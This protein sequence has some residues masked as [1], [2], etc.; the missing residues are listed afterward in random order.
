MENLKNIWE[1]VK[2]WI[3][4]FLDTIG[5]VPTAILKVVLIIVAAK[6]LIVI[7]AAIIKRTLYRKTQK[8]PG[9]LAAKKSETIATLITSASKYL[10]YFIGAI[11]ILDAIG[12]GATIGSVIATAGIGGIALSLGAQS[13][14]K[15]VVAGFF[16]LLEDEYAVGDLVEICGKQGTVESI[17]L[18]TTRLRLF[19][20]EILAI[21]NGMVDLVINYTRDSY[22]LPYTASI[23]YE[24]DEDRAAALLMEAASELAD[25]EESILE[26]P[27]YLGISRTGADGIDI[28][29]TLKVKPQDQWQ[30]ERDL[31]AAVIRA[32]KK[33]GIKLPLHT[34]VT[35]HNK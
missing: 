30:I 13:F 23:A 22:T 16:I 11:A 32:F 3:S 8:A 26:A 34:N 2:D 6:L 20:N 27:T 31:N 1:S 29:I 14:I 9:T 24:E 15:D 7:V 17:S 4:D 25:K 21:P 28:K 5:P 12:L 19:K 35:V 18:R 10:V 33:H